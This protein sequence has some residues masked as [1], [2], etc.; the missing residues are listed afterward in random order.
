MDVVSE[1]ARIVGVT[2]VPA[3]ILD[4]DSDLFFV[5]QPVVSDIL[6][7]TAVGHAQAGR[8]FEFDSRAQRK[9]EDGQA[10]VVSL[11]NASAAHGAQY[12]VKFRMLLKLH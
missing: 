12:I 2:A 9:V 8:V 5:Y 4:E 6:V 1:P 11:E 10:I 3:P 7:A